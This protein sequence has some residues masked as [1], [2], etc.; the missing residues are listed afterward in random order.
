MKYRSFLALAMGLLTLQGAQALVFTD[1]PWQALLD[2]GRR[3]EME[4]L[5]LLSLRDQPQDLQ[6]RV[7]FALSQ[8]SLAD[9]KR[10]DAA[11]RQMQDCVDQQPQEAL[12]HYALASVMTMQAM[13]GGAMKIISLAAPIR[14]HLQRALEL[15]PDFIEARSSLHQYYLLVPAFAG[16]GAAKAREL[17]EQVRTSQPEFAKLM[18]ARVAG[19]E[20]NWALAEKE[21]LSVRVGADSSLLNE[22]RL[23]WGVLGKEWLDQREYAKAM[24]GF[25]RVLKEQPRAALGAYGLARIHFAMGEH[26]EAIKQYERAKQMDGAEDYPLDHRLGMAYQAKGDLVQAKAAYERYLQNRRASPSNADDC[27]KR[28]KEI[29]PL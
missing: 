14:K 7:A 5:A 25:E 27:R 6:A 18:R 13:N 23:V 15:K 22:W 4:R 20:K 10:V 21:L 16:G 9:R 19:S 1:G 28:L 24:A 26:D 2:A 11:A 3:D 8:M 17:E 29:G 12:C